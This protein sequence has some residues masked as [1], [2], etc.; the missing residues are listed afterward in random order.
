MLLNKQKLQDTMYYKWAFVSKNNIYIYTYRRTVE[1]HTQLIV[2][3][4]AG[5]V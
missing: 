4:G 3:S 2:V 5:V 1:E